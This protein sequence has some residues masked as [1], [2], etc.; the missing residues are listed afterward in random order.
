MSMTSIMAT[1]KLLVPFEEG[2][3]RAAKGFC[4]CEKKVEHQVFETFTC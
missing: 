2:S 1:G 3:C 4:I